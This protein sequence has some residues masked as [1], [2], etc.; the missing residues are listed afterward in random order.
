MCATRLRGVRQQT[1]RSGSAAR[2]NHR[3]QG[4][5]TENSGVHV[6]TRRKGSI[7][8]R[9]LRRSCENDRIAYSLA[10]QSQVAADGV[11]QTGTGD[12]RAITD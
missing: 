2:D 12:L 5:P 4:N 9:V 8:R 1:R 7:G 10:I 11:Q 6:V 3:S